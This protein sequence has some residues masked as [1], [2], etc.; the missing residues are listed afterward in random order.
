MKKGRFDSA[1]NI[2]YLLKI[3]ASEIALS[4]NYLR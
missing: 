1:I 3:N 2:L 4:K